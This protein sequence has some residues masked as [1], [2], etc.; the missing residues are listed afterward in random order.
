[1]ADRLAA[2]MS[3]RTRFPTSLLTSSLLACSRVCSG[4]IGHC[5]AKVHETCV[6]AVAMTTTSRPTG[7]R[8]RSSHAAPPE[9]TPIAELIQNLSAPDIRVCP[10]T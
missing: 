1:M 8:S 2:R 10:F 4:S 7:Q 3:R 9:T 6:A 5:T